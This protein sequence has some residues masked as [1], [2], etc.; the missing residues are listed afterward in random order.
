MF[1]FG[2]VSSFTVAIT[3][4]DQF[5]SLLLALTSW[6]TTWL[7]YLHSRGLQDEL[8]KTMRFGF[9][10]CT[11]I[12]GFITFGLIAWSKPFL[13]C[14]ILTPEAIESGRIDPVFWQDII[15]CVVLMVLAAAVRSVFEPNV[16][17]LYA[18]AQHHY[19]AFSTILEGILN[20]VLCILFASQWGLVGF[21]W[22]TL[23]ASVIMRGFFLP[24]IVCRLME[25]NFLAH[26]CEMLWLF[27]LVGIALIVPSIVTKLLVAPNYPSLFL[28]G[29]ISTVTYFPVIYLIGFSSAERRKIHSYI[30]PGGTK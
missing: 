12:S 11:Y 17:Y 25:R 15:P 23:I 21:A 19:Y 9:K 2:F 6:M 24:M 4:A 5:R 1:G 3:F 18:M 13:T 26:Y 7:T 30:F 22:G 10:F 27:L 16:R 28:V 20:L 14:W 8:L 29:G